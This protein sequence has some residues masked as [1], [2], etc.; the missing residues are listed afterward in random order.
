M[1][2]SKLPKKPKQSPRYAAVAILHKLQEYGHVAYFAGGCVRDALLGRTPKDYDIA[3]D[4][5]PDRVR[6]LF[7][8][9]RFVGEA[10]GVVRVH[11]MGHDIEVAT[12][13]LE[14]GYVDGRRPGK[15]K[16][17]DAQHDAQ[18]RDFTING[19]FE[20]PLAKEKGKRIIDY[21]GGRADLDRGVIRA[22][23]DP[24]D[25]F[26]EDYLRML[27]AV[28]FAARL[29]FTIDPDTAGAIAPL[30][31]NLGRISRERIGQEVQMMLSVDD[32]ARR[33]AA[34]ATLTQTQLDGPSLD[35][36]HMDSPLPTVAALAD[37]ASYATVLAAWLLD[38]QGMDDEENPPKQIIKRW[39]KA[40]CL[41]N[42]DRDLLGHLLKQVAKAG[43]WIDSGKAA[44]KR[45][46]AD[47]DWEQTLMLLRA[48]AGQ[49]E[50]VARI[51][52]DTKLLRDEGIAPAP[53]VT[54]EDLIAIRRKPGPQFSRLLDA[55]YDAQLDGSVKSRDEALQ[56]LADQ[57][58][59]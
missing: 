2:R 39:R 57:P 17:T 23:G 16:F 31:E 42:E 14:W 56:W 12:F 44:R 15:V 3:T 18:R 58:E 9:S 26:A 53:W 25:R 7:P 45:L 4:A 55:V 33:T 19:L 43:Q 34:V 52:K 59:S 5:D 47:D 11:M 36:D 35:E 28:R 49:D 54:G 6:L 1:V 48:V 10:F 27:R 50:I 46:L 51:D 21:V 41:S 30:A 38:R 20:N 8:H 22:I 37:K 32:A 13:R 24:R 29:G 40:L